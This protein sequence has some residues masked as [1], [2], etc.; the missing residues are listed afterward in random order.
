MVVDDYLHVGAGREG[1]TKLEAE[2]IELSHF[3]VRYE[4]LPD[5]KK[6]IKFQNTR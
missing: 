1:Y 4:D 6:K 3:H 2:S 5:N